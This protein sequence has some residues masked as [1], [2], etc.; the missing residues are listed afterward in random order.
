[1]FNGGMD[2][3]DKRARALLEHILVEEGGGK[4]KKRR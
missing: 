2:R 4:S 1:M 3:G